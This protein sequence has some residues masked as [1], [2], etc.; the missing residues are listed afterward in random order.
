MNLSLRQMLEGMTLTFDTVAAGNTEATIQFNVTGEEPGTYHLRI[1]SGDCIFHV[2]AA[3]NP[4]LTITTPSDVWLKIISK[5]LDRKDALMQ[6]LYQVNGDL[7]LLMRMSTLFK[8]PESRSDGV[9]A[10]AAPREQRP[11]GPIAIPGMAWMTVALIPWI[12]FW[13]T[14]HIHGVSSW[15]SIGFP[16][17]FTL[18]IIIYRRVFDKPTLMEWGGLG[19]FTLAGI[20]TLVGNPTLATWGTGISQII[21]GGLWLG[22]LVFTDMPLCGEYSKWGYI[23]QL[24]RTSLFIH[25]NA[26]I[27]LMWGWLYLGQAAIGIGAN[28]LPHLDIPLTVIRYI[29]LVPA[30]IFTSSYQKGSA[31]R[32]IVDVDRA[33][34]KISISAR[35]GLG[36]AVGIVLTI[37]FV[38]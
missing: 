23:K 6:G 26:V 2:G 20:L 29:L 11:A 14:F 12:V 24:P 10:Y 8:T 1:A 36:V 27:S 15:V 28:L 25:P 7:S 22:S 33:L 17:F 21:L 9:S 3:E 13:V 32:R 19:F 4:T 38:L 16:F 35:I 30:F 31:N 34:A 5:E 18:F 37:L